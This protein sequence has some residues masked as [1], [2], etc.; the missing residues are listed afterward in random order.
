MFLTWFEQDLQKKF[1]TFCWSALNWRI[2]FEKPNNIID[3]NPIGTSDW[4][5]RFEK[6]S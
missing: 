3:H 2:P 6:I 4:L 1:R 5:L